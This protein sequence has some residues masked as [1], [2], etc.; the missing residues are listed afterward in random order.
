MKLYDSDGDDDGSQRKTFYANDAAKAGFKGFFG[1][2]NKQRSPT[3]RLTKGNR[4]KFGL[5]L[6]PFEVNSMILSQS[7]S[8]ELT[9]SKE[10]KSFGH[11]E[12][13]SNDQ[14]PT[15]NLTPNA[16]ANGAIF[17]LISGDRSSALV[18]IEKSLV[19]DSKDNTNVPNQRRSQLLPS[20]SF[21]VPLSSKKVETTPGQLSLF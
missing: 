13:K 20:S 3:L 7:E 10:S 12:K 17:N 21:S 19:P 18:D 11:L 16:N 6:N 2:V 9:E 1:I 15:Y 4:G 5:S 14:T 8:D